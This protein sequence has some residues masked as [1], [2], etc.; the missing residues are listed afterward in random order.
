MKTIIQYL[1]EYKKESILS[2]L[3]KMLEAFFDL[4]VPLVIAR[5]INQGI[6]LKNWSS[7]WKYILLLLILALI[8]MSCSFV[9][10]YFAAKASVGVSSKLR[11]HLFDHIQSFR[12]H[13]WMFWVLI[14]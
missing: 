10:Q 5:L 12:F 14:P 11:Q 4:L 3:F 2:P 1:K 6:L 13:N 8:G 7:I 9:A